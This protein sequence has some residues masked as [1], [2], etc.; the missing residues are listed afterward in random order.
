MLC[1]PGHFNF[2]AGLATGCELICNPL[3]NKQL[4]ALRSHSLG[5]RNTSRKTA[6]KTPLQK[7]PWQMQKWASNKCNYHLC[8][9]LIASPLLQRCILL[10]KRSYRFL[11]RSS[12]EGVG[13]RS[14][15]SSSQTKFPGGGVKRI[16]E[17]TCCSSD[18]R[19]QACSWTSFYYNS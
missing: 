14:H 16:S 19:S 1:F 5:E 3:S 9:L 6:G 12:N 17:A 2:N 11:G 7:W 10:H 15:F 13:G 8:H 18:G 4:A